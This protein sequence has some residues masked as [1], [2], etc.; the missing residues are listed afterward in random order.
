MVT[1]LTVIVLFLSLIV[2][3]MCV[4]IRW[5]MRWPNIFKM[6]ALIFGK[7]TVQEAAETTRMGLRVLRQK[8]EE[9]EKKNGSLP[10]ATRSQG[11]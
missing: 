5:Q 2:C 9:A 3:G 11:R 4:Y 7:S 10:P 6:L 8:L 1:V